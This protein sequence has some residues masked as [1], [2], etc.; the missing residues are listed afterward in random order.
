[1]LLDLVADLGVTFLLKAVRL[2]KSPA[3]SQRD[4]LAAELR[5]I[6]AQRKKGLLS[7][8]EYERERGQILSAVD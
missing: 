4:R 1:M 8:E 5:A 2:S 6:D 7:P 3:D